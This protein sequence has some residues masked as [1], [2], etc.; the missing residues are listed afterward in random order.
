MLYCCFNHLYKLDPRGFAV[1]AELLRDNERTWLWL[2]RFPPEVRMDGRETRAGGVSAVALVCCVHC[3][4][5]W[6][7][8]LHCSSLPIRFAE[9]SIC[10]VS[11]QFA[12]PWLVLYRR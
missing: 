1:W 11:D 3:A 2:P 8:K 6:R 12:S 4:I 9:L 5:D 7:H 10:R